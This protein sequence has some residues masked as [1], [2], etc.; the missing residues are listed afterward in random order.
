MSVSHPPFLSLPYQHFPHTISLPL[1]NLPNT[2][3]STYTHLPPSLSLHPQDW[4][5]LTHKLSELECSLP[6]NTLDGKVLFDS[7]REKLCWLQGGFGWWRC[8]WDAERKVECKESNTLK[9]V[10]R[11]GGGGGGSPDRF[12]NFLN[13]VLHGEPTSVAAGAFAVA[14]GHVR[15][16]YTNGHS[17]H[18]SPCCLLCLQQLLF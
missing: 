4:V 6:V 12:N 17:S 2:P 3:A 5:W 18:L 1:L 14:A 16:G 11:E 8:S 7:R 13:S 10:C 15:E 9:G